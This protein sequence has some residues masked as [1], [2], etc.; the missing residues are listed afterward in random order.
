MN[1]RRY[2]LHES[3][4]FQYFFLD[5]FFAFVQRN[6]I[7]VATGAFGRVSWWR[8]SCI[9]NQTTHCFSWYFALRFRLSCWKKSSFCSFLLVL[10]H[11]FPL[12]FTLD[13]IH[14]N[15][16]DNEKNSSD[17]QIRFGTDDKILSEIGINH[18]ETFWGRN[19]K[20][21]SKRNK[22]WRNSKAASQ[23][24]RYRDSIFSTLCFFFIFSQ[25]HVQLIWKIA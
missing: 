4:I 5:F 10:S 21:E 8:F 18:V 17:L 7:A 23:I 15:D 11:F 12:S 3:F 24:S 16:D 9:I 2:N 19:K 6:L 1:L 25:F 22:I 13:F 20:P 14:A